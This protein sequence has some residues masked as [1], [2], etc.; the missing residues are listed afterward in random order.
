MEDTVGFYGISNLPILAFWAPKAIGTPVGS[1][2]TRS[3]TAKQK[4]AWLALVFTVS[5]ANNRCGPT[6][7]LEVRGNGLTVVGTKG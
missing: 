3:V 5:D 4:D 7:V 1:F 6:G 2:Q